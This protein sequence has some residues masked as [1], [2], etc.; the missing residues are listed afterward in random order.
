M[1]RT[2]K[3]IKF[4]VELLT[5]RALTLKSLHLLTHSLLSHRRKVK[6]LFTVHYCTVLQ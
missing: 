6:I 2:Q 5:L 1:A 4:H 3:V